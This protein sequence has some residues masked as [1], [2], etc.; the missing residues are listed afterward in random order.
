MRTIGHSTFAIFIAF[1]ASIGGC[2]DPVIRWEIAYGADVDRASIAATRVDIYAVDCMFG[3]DASP[4]YT[5]WIVNDV[6][7]QDQPELPL[8]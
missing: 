4:L 1:G 2:G 7:L 6:S 5:T 3:G 8:T